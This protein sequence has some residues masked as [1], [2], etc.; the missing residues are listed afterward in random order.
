MDSFV[1]VVAGIRP[2]QRASK[3]NSPRLR[4][5]SSLACSP[6]ASQSSPLPLCVTLSTLGCATNRH[7][8]LCCPTCLCV[9]FCS[10]RRCSY[11]VLPPAPA[12]VVPALVLARRSPSPAVSVPLV[13]ALLSAD[14]CWPMLLG[15]SNL[16]RTQLP[17]TAP[18]AFTVVSG[19]AAARR[20]ATRARVAFQ[21][22]ACR[23]LSARIKLKSTAAQHTRII[24]EQDGVRYGGDSEV[25][26]CGSR[27]QAPACGLSSM[28]QRNTRCVLGAGQNTGFAI[29]LSIG[30]VCSSGCLCSSCCKFGFSNF[31]SSVVVSSNCDL[32]FSKKKKRVFRT[33][34]DGVENQ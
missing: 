21:V 30:F 20:S 15:N 10:C 18:K 7:C 29:V 22:Q 14:I 5:T 28:R 19:V 26:R 2:G 31:C 4:P 8:S 25:G 17:A 23:K 34:S 3:S 33:V 32:F 6:S 27:L 13:V 16:Q 12:R 11:L 24:S 1:V 9:C